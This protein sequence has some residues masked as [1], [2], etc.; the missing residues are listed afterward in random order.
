LIFFRCDAN[1]NI[2]MGHLVRCRTLAISLNKIGEKCSMIGPADSYK[3][4]ADETIFTKWVHLPFSKTSSKDALNVLKIIDN[5]SFK[6]L[7]LDDHRVD[8]EY[9]IELKRSDI[10]WLQFDRGKIN[11]IWANIVLNTNPIISSI[12]YD[13]VIKNS[14]AKLLLGPKYAIVRSEFSEQTILSN[15]RSKRVLVCFGGGSDRGAILFVLNS[16]VKKNNDNYVFIVI[17]GKNNPNND[18][19]NNWVKEHAKG[20]A[21]LFVN[22]DSIAQLFA[23][24]DIAIMAGGSSIYEALCFDLPIILLSIAENQIYHAKSWSKITHKINYLGPLGEVTPSLLKEKFN[25]MKGYIEKNISPS[26][27]LVDGKGGDRVA[28]E[29]VNYLK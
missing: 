9:Q 26:Q 16:L 11:S 18:Q 8:E 28:T 27:Q 12:E 4:S 29:I 10:K 2:G 17:S 13:L 20:N 15:S 6:F 25:E 14:N 7:I 3:T 23:S 5:S 19:I 24:C 22:P 21:S 1:P